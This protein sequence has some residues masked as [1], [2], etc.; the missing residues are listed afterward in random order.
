[1]VPQSYLNNRSLSGAIGRRETAEKKR[2]RVVSCLLEAE[3]DARGGGEGGEEEEDLHLRLCLRVAHN[4]KKKQE[5][6]TYGHVY[7]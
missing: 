6:K 5:K 7:T 1:M 3:E 4:R 2:L